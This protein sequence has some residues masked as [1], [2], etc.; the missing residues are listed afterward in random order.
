MNINAADV[1]AIAASI[2]ALTV[3]SAFGEWVRRTSKTAVSRLKRRQHKELV[4]VLSSEVA[5]GPGWDAVMASPEVSFEA[6]VAYARAAATSGHPPYV[7]TRGV[8]SPDDPLD[9]LLDK[10]AESVWAA[11]SSTHSE[12][13]PY[14]LPMRN[15]LRALVG[16]AGLSPARDFALGLLTERVR[17]EEDGWPDQPGDPGG[18]RSAHGTGAS[19]QCLLERKHQVEEAIYGLRTQADELPGGE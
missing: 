7:P 13:D 6:G 4:Q 18:K 5:A 8:A 15:Y 19:H 2:T 9:Y 16:N 10:V 14:L 12:L 11:A 17:Q 3:V 1:S